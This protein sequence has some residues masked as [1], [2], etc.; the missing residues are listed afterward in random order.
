M[1]KKHDFVSVQNG[2]LP[3]IFPDSFPLFPFHSLFSL[4]VCLFFI[5]IYIFVFNLRL[6]AYCIS[7]CMYI[8]YIKTFKFTATYVHFSLHLFRLSFLSSIY[9]YFKGMQKTYI[10]G[11]TTLIYEINCAIKP[12]FFKIYFQPTRISTLP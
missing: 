10:S 5:Y 6:T 2:G 12:V 1:I 9:A 11:P 7:M 3:Y 8:T 4:F